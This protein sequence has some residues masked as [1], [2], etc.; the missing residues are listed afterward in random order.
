[1][2]CTWLHFTESCL[3]WEVGSYWLVLSKEQPL[4]AFWANIRDFRKPSGEFPASDADPECFQL[5]RHNPQDLQFGITRNVHPSPTPPPPMGAPRGL[6]SG[7]RRGPRETRAA[8]F[9][10]QRWPSPRG[11]S[12]PRAPTTMQSSNLWLLGRAFGNNQGAPDL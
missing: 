4:L 12:L 8:A 2:P 1:M 10:R 3:G 7:W 9:E 5:R 11:L 6:G